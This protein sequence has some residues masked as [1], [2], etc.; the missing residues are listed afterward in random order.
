M[1]FKTTVIPQTRARIRNACRTRLLDFEYR[2]LT[3]VRDAALALQN[4]VPTGDVNREYYAQSMESKVHLTSQFKESVTDNTP[5]TLQLAA[6]RSRL[7]SARAASAAKG[8][9]KQLA[10]SQVESAAHLFVPCERRVQLGIQVSIQVSANCPL[11]VCNLT[12]PS[13]TRNPDSALAKQ[14]IQ[15]RCHGC[16]DLV[17]QKPLWSMLTTK[18][19]NPRRHFNR[20]WLLDLMYGHTPTYDIQMSLFLSLL[21]KVFP[22]FCCCFVVPK[23][24]T[25]YLFE[26]SSEAW[27]SL[28]PAIISSCSTVP[29]SRFPGS[30]ITAAAKPAFSVGGLIL[31]GVAIGALRST[32]P[33]STISTV[34]SLPNVA[35]S[36]LLAGFGT[37]V[38]RTLRQI[39]PV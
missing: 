10:V 24:R 37:K 34:N 9:S 17:A 22:C 1:R 14:S 35:V 16:N 31:G 28:W 38:G 18:A 25:P 30:S 21:G 32:V 26:P 23:C 7:E 12:R 6:S 33:S 2:L 11:R 36:G 5:S 13:G 27:T 15:D 8:M 20:T 29:S 19:S 4:K 3:Q 39:S